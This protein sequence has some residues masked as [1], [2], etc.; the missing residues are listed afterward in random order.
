MGGRPQT[1]RS[2][3]EGSASS[4]AELAAAMAAAEAGRALSAEEREE[5]RWHA[6]MELLSSAGDPATAAR[7]K[8]NDLYRA[9]RALEVVR[10]T[11]RPLA[12]FKP[13]AEA[14][15]DASAFDFR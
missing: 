11:G 3:A 13:D 8:R 1:P 14:A 5:V 7:L 15:A 9:E 10:A 6:A 2:S 12:D 4:R